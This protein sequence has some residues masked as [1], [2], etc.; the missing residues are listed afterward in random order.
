MKKIK[1]ILTAILGISLIACNNDDDNNSDYSN[2]NATT[3]IGQLLQSGTDIVAMVKKDSAYTIIDGVETTEIHYINSEG[4][5]TKA[6]IT[7]VDLTSPNI[8]IETSTPNNLPAYGRQKMTEQALYEDQEG[9]KVWAGFNGDFFNESNGI[10]RGIV[11]KDGVV[12]KGSFTD[13]VNTWFA[14]KND[15]KAAIG[16]QEEY[17]DENANFKEA[18]SGR[19]TLLS[20]G[21][22]LSQTDET[23]EP[24]TG[25]GVSQDGLKVYFLVVDGRNFSY[26]NGINY[27]GM[28]QIFSALG[29]YDA[30]NLDGGGS[31]TFFSRITPDFS[32]N[33]FEL[34]NWPS[35][36]G[37]QERTVANGLVIIANN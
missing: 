9:H 13:N 33:R 11:Y 25:V 22:I 14:I 24:R 1:Y 32:E 29:A 10:P 6:F 35:D 37:G 15:G 23:L 4:Y 3:E 2:S 28:A 7:T 5:S 12:I 31:T 18:V 19:V 30:I 17:P 36:N 21:L 34:R 26:S 27:N 20:D 8:S 16:N